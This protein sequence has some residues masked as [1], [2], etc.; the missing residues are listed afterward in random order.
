MQIFLLKGAQGTLKTSIWGA[1]IREF[2]E[3][4]E[5]RVLYLD[6]AGETTADFSQLVADR[7]DIVI[8]DTNHDEI[9][10]LGYEPDFTI[11]IEQKARDRALPFA[12]IADQQLIADFLKG[13][14]MIMLEEVSLTCLGISQD[15]CTPEVV[16][17]LSD[18]ICRCGWL[19]IRPTWT[20]D[21][22][23]PANSPLT[24]NKSS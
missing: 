13:R 15:A 6:Y 21:F 2:F 5:N 24:Q 4:R 3:T 19:R 20:R 12:R 18:L 16:A 9:P 17:T 23:V 10:V 11:T 22:F 7:P 1:A 8:I 14:D